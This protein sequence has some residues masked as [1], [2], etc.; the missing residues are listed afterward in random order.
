[1]DE[2]VLTARRP[3]AAPPSW[4]PLLEPA[5]GGDGLPGPGHESGLPGESWPKLHTVEYLTKLI[6][7]IILLFALPW[8]LGKL[9]SNPEKVH[10]G[11]VGVGA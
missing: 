1:M 8:V 6:T 3:L 7:L 11:P 4:L 2:A 5:G 10:V 9:L